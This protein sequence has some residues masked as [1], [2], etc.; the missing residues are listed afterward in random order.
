MDEEL[1][2]LSDA[3]KCTFLL[4]WS[5][6]QVLEMYQVWFLE[7]CTYNHP[8]WSKREDFCKPQSNE[9]RVRYD[10]FKSFS[11]AGSYVDGWYYTVLNQLALCGY[12]Q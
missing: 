6:D 5:G 2:S 1:A 7:S 3:R 11:Q 4:R 9:L 12:P 8:L 10:L